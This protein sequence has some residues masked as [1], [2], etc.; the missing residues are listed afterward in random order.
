M[1]ILSLSQSTFVFSMLENHEKQNSNQN[2]KVEKMLVLVKTFD[3]YHHKFHFF[4]CTVKLQR[5]LKLRFRLKFN[6]GFT[7]PGY[8]LSAV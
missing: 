8:L 7:S 2:M 1:K 6:H 5:N 4:K 3:Y